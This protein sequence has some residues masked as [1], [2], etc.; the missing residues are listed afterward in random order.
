MIRRP[1]RSTLFPYTTLFRSGHERTGDLALSVGG[2][3]TEVTQAG[4]HVAHVGAVD[5]DGRRERAGIGLVLGNPRAR[6]HVS[7]ERD[8]DGRQD[9]DDRDD[10]HQLDEGEASLVRYREPLFGPPPNHWDPPC[11]ALHERYLILAM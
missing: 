7:V 10:D 11:F 6:L 9:A 1:P 3:H 4:G 2:N 8:G 5:R